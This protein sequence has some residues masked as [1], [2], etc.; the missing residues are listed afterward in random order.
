MSA[1]TAAVVKAPW[2]LARSAQ[3]AVA[4]TALADVYRA[5][6]LRAHRLDP[7]ETPL[8]VSGRVSTLF[9]YVSLA[10]V[11]LFLMWFSRCRRNARLLSPEPLAGSP[12]WAVFAWLIPVVNFWAP[13]GL[14]LDVHGASGPGAAEGR[15]RALVNIWWAAWVGHA[16]VGAVGMGVAGGTSLAVLLVTEFLELAAGALAIAVIQRV[17]ARQSAALAGTGPLPGAAVLPRV[18]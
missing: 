7:Q 13:R 9:V 1:V 8:S 18:S 16:L 11:V 5:V 15:D 4:V 17:T 2:P 14:V 10:T 12:A 6:T 3:A